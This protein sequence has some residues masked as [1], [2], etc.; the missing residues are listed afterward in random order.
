MAKISD[1]VPAEIIPVTFDFSSL[2]LTAVDSVVSVT[3]TVITGTDAAAAAM[4]QGA[5]V[6]TGVKAVQLVKAGVAGVRYNLACLAAVG[7]ER[8]Q[9]D[10]MMDV[11]TRHSK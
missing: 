10:G 11:V 2:P 4:L 6:L 8:Y 3:V 5:P 1:K 9:I 7:A